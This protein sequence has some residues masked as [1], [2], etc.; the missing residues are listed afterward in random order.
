VDLEQHRVIDLLPDRTTDTVAAWLKNQPSIEVI[1]RDRAGAYAEAARQGAPQAQ[2][3]A[4]RWHLLQNLTEALQRVVERHYGRLREIIQEDAES[5]DSEQTEKTWTIS[6]PNSF[7]EQL[8]QGRLEQ[9][10]ARCAE[11]LRLHKQGMPILTIARHL[12]MHRR[13]VRQYIRIGVIPR[14]AFSGRRRQLDSY[15]SFAIIR[16]FAVLRQTMKAPL[17]RRFPQ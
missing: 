2:Q 10:Q 15:V 6:P 13:L 5:V 14:A 12:Q 11:V 4:D 3:V 8:R 7:A 9:K 1:S 16:F 17:P